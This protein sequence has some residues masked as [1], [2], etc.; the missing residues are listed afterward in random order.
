M[1]GVQKSRFQV[2]KTLRVNIMKQL[3]NKYRTHDYLKILI[4][5]VCTIAHLF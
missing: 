3:R 5:H 4:E 1:I 2:A